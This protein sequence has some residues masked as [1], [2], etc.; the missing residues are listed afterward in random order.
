MIYSQ[1]VAADDFEFREATPG[2]NDEVVAVCSSALGW[3][4]PEFDHALF[5]WKH[6]DNAF[7]RSVLLVA[8]DEHGIAA[9]R[10]FMRWTFRD[11]T[12][13]TFHAARAVDTATHPRAQGKGLF[14]RLTTFGIDMLEA[15]NVDFIFNTP[16]EKSL[17]GYLKMGWVAAGP[18]TFGYGVRSPISLTRTARSRTA[19]AKHS[20]PIPNIGIS[21][22]EGLDLINPTPDFIANPDD[23]RP[24]AGTAPSAELPANHA[25]ETAHSFESLR[26]RYGSAPMDYR[27]LVGPD[28]SGLIVR[29]R[30]R[31]SA[32]ELVVAHRIGHLDNHDAGRAIRN[33]MAQA[34]ADHCIGW[35]GL[36]GTVS[37]PTLGPALALRHVNNPPP[38]SIDWL[39]GDIE[40]F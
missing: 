20:L 13:Q 19:A 9:V 17:P 18:V 11:P 38:S 14:T 27:F 35:A 30:Q 15:Q 22:D 8:V 31:G 1:P 12:G 2:D 33:A 24:F 25:L 34:R 6:F 4:D 16:N 32:R 29:L 39:P 37:L 28:R 40:I 21:V 26:W 5:R 23:A 7:G 3:T 36:G 10:P